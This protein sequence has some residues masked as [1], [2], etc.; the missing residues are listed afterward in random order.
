M[1]RLKTGSEEGLAVSLHDGI[2]IIIISLYTF[3]ICQVVEV[4]GKGRGVITTR[5]FK[6]GELL[7]EYTG[8]LLTY[9]EG[10][11]KEREYAKDANIGC[12]MYF[13]RYI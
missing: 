2:T 12:Y 10:I 13:F 11:K 9:E 1:T 4:K 6:K 5:K 7:C 3:T 8:N